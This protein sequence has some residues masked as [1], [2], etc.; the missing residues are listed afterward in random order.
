MEIAIILIVVG[1]AV[2]LNVVATWKVRRSVTLTRF[3]QGA[4]MGASQVLRRQIRL[5]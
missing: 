3:Q 4:Q 1:L 2:F 5:V